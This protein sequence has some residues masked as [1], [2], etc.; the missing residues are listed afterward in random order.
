M[1]E[2][3]ESLARIEKAGEYEIP[4]LSDSDSGRE[5]KIYAG[6]HDSSRYLARRR[7]EAAQADPGSAPPALN[8]E[9]DLVLHYQDGRA[10]VSAKDA[11]KDLASYRE[12]LAQQLLEGADLG[13]AAMRASGYEQPAEAPQPEA[14]PAEQA[15]PPTYTEEQVQQGAATSAVAG[16]G[17][18][19]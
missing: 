17:T 14:Q 19:T 10:E 15:P 5:K 7:R 16:Y 3:R 6:A 4:A 13:T 9:P 12:R 2:I 18:G 11:A 1:A 8:A